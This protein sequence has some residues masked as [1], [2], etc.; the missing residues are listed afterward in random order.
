MEIK[1]REQLGKKVYY[2]NIEV[3]IVD[4]TI[5]NDE[6]FVKLQDNSGNYSEWIH[7]Q[8]SN[9]TPVPQTVSQTYTYISNLFG[10]CPSII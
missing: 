5:D 7:T 8:N 3:T 2:K 10:T 4:F 9:L 1:L 6:I